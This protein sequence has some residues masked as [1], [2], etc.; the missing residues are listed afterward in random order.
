VLK[1]KSTVLP[2]IVF[3]DALKK[4]KRSQVLPMKTLTVVDL[5]QSPVGRRVKV[6]MGTSPKIVGFKS[7]PKVQPLANLGQSTNG[8]GVRKIR[9][10]KNPLANA[11]QSTRLPPITTH[12]YELRFP[13]PEPSPL[14]QKKT[15]G[16][17]H[18][19]S[20]TARAQG[21]T[22]YRDTS[23]TSLEKLE[24]DLQIKGIRLST[25]KLAAVTASPGKSIILRRPNIIL[26]GPP[27]GLRTPPRT[28]RGGKNKQK[29]SQPRPLDA[30]LGDVK[31]RR[32]K[33][34]KYP[35]LVRKGN[36][37]GVMNGNSA[38]EHAVSVKP[39]YARL[40]FEWLHLQ[41]RSLGGPNTIANLVAGTFDANTRMTNVERHVA[42]RRRLLK[43]GEFIDYR[44]R[45]E[46]VPG[47]HVASKISI[48]VMFP[49]RLKA[50]SV[51]VK[52]DLNPLDNTKYTNAEYLLNNRLLAKGQM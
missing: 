21:L 42:L 39:E 27:Q 9:V 48:H 26:A 41:A 51:S 36:L 2:T 1:R 43:K 25:G 8:S 11:G 49:P 37:R 10:I 32:V 22:L 5:N 46:L 19:I 33:L 35:T 4:V 34:G 7:P 12:P 24:E 14:P 44:V 31:E 16:G 50:G 47:T 15:G 13:R 17:F 23:S 38:F 28:P 29:V 45:A 18:P 40:R 6:R 20:R 52:L 30:V 3:V